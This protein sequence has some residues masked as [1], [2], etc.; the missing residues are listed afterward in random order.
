[1]T[2]KKYT[3]LETMIDEEHFLVSLL[4]GNQEVVQ[5]MEVNTAYNNPINCVAFAL[6]DINMDGYLDV[7]LVTA[8]GNVNIAYDV[9]LWNPEQEKLEKCEIGIQRK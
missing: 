1:M 4:D 6:D 3:L 2:R 9:Y 8:M 7:P 5:E